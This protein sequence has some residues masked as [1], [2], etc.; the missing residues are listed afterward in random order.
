[1]KYFGLKVIEIIIFLCLNS[2]IT[3]KVQLYVSIFIDYSKILT[4]ETLREI[5]LF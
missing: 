3:K 1:M 2:L 4:N 5:K